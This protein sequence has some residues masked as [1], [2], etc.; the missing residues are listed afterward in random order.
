MVECLGWPSPQGFV[1][2][3]RWE[4]HTKDG[5]A[6]SSTLVN[7]WWVNEAG[8]ITRCESSINGEELGPVMEL[9][10]GRRGPFASFDDYW[11]ALA[12]R[13]RKQES[14]V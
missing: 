6:L 14:A 7:F 12:A 4:G 9:V 10:V 1:T 8:E 13:H 2:R 5:K 3:T 11:G